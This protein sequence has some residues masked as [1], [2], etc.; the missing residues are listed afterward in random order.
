MPIKFTRILAIDPG[1]KEIGLAVLEGDEL[2]YYGVKTIRKRTAPEVILSEAE[3]AVGQ[4]IREYEPLVLAIETIPLIQ[5]NAAFVVA[6][7]ER[8]KKT[9]KQEGLRILEF[10]PAFVRRSMCRTGKA[11]KRKVAEVVAGRYPELAQYFDRK[12]YWEQLYWAKLFDAVAI[13]LVCSEH[14]S[15]DK[16][17]SEDQ[18]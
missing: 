11:T 6:V 3:R 18:F 7:A 13:G 16:P 10:S 12:T 8:I 1:S 15:G 2:V 5:T 17:S 9:A 4:I 14:I